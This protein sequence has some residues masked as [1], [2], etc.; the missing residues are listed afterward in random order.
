MK[1]YKILKN[2]KLVGIISTFKE[3]KIK[4]IHYTLLEISEYEY[5]LLNKQ[6]YYG[7]EN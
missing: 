2:S 3:D 7:K 1:F 6:F 4:E 5:N